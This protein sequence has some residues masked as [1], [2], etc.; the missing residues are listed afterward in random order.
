MS[1]YNRYLAGETVQVYKDIENLGLDAFSSGYKED[2]ENVLTETFQRVAYNLEV[3]Y[4]ELK[5]INYH[6]KLSP[7]EVYQPN[8]E[9][10]KLLIELD[11]SAGEF[12][13]VPL[14]L[15]FFYKIVGGVNLCWDFDTY[16]EIPWKLSDPLEIDSLDVLVNTISKDWWKDYIRENLEDPEVGIPFIELAADQFH[17]DNIDGGPPYAIQ[18]TEGPSVDSPFLYEQHHTSFIN[19]LRISFNH[20]GF[21]G[22]KTPEDDFI[23]FTDRVRTKL[24]AI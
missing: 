23:A 20:C 10:A 5:A 11:N 6:F 16:P 18:L 3:I 7:E 13:Y 8:Q 15:Q 19:Y 4:T 14:S 2:V 24:K 22:M 21:P 9:T 1:L 12:G 17:K